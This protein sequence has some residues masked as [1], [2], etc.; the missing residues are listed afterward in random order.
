MLGGSG[1]LGGLIA[2]ELHRHGARLVLAGRDAER[3]HQRASSISADV[4]SVLF[5]LREPSHAEHVVR[6]AVEML[7]GLDGV[8]NA[9]GVVAFGAHDTLGGAALDELFA[10]DLVGPL[11]VISAALPHMEQGFLV[12]ISGVV[13]E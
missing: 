8:V 9:A 10:V 13:A 3:L 7:G 6:T 11:Q 4:Q 2:T 12:N 1:V 5:D